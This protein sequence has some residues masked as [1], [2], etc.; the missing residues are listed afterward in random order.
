MLHVIR[1]TGL[2]V[3]LD[4][5]IGPIYLREKLE[6]AFPDRTIFVPEDL[7]FFKS[8]PLVVPACSERSY[9]SSHN[10]AFLLRRGRPLPHSVAPPPPRTS[11]TAIV[12]SDGDGDEDEVDAI[13][14]T[15]YFIKSTPP[16]LLSVS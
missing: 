10:P 14:A 1:R 5:L 4:A 3:S 16:C 12:A 6:L 15:D 11:R 9:W 8:N 7:E 2:V 13:L